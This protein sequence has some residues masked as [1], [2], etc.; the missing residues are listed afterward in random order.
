MC[1]CVLLLLLL[2]SLLLLLFFCFVVDVVCCCFLGGREGRG[3][4]LILLLFRCDSLRSGG[5]DYIL[6]GDYA[7]RLD[8]SFAA[9]AV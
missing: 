9:C 1:V 4:I 3:C 5:D 7:I 6:S 2:L 8:E